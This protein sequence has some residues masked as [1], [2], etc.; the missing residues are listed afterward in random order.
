[1]IRSIFNLVVAD[2]DGSNEQILLKSSEPI[3]SPSW[4]PDSK[5]VAYVSFETGMAKVFIQTIATGKREM[6]LENS[7]QISSP[8]W[9]PNGKFLIA[10]LV[11]RWKCR[12]IYFKFKK[13]KPYK[14]RPIIMQLILNPHGRQMAQRLCLLLADLDR[15]NYMKLI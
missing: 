4:S 9:S 6:V 13:S 12:N 11:S 15:H 5:K 14:T 10:N 3:I 1:M 8:S 2:S 7:S